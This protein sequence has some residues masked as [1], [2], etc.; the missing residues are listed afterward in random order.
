ML[1]YIAFEEEVTDNQA[2]GFLR[3]VFSNEIGLEAC[4][5]DVINEFDRRYKHIF[6]SLYSFF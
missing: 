4:P 1:E 2:L 6:P 5:M 3:L